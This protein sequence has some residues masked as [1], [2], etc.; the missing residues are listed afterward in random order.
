[1]RDLGIPYLLIRVAVRDLS[2][3]TLV[4]ARTALAALLLL[5]IA[6][7]RGD[8]RAV[9]RRWLPLLAFTAVEIAAPWLLLASAE[10]RVSSSLTALL[11]AAVPLTGP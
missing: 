2:P 10:K 9:V 6:A 1:M 3:A 11:I 7:A 4:F 8:V 5:P